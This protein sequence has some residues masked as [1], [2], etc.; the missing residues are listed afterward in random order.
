MFPNT[1]FLTRWFML[2]VLEHLLH[3][4]GVNPHVAHHASTKACSVSQLS[5]LSK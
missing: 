1:W 5:Q 2:Y 4:G 3:A